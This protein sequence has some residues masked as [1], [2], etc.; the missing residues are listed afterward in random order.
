MPP[1]HAMLCVLALLLTA[2][3]WLPGPNKV[4]NSA[5]MLQFIRNLP[6][7]LAALLL[8]MATGGAAQ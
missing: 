4:P 5:R 6:T 2:A 1:G 8:A 7:G 3:T